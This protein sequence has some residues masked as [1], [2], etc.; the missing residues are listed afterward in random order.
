MK[1]TKEHILHQDFVLS[2]A[3]YKKLNKHD[4]EDADVLRKLVSCDYV[5][6]SHKFASRFFIKT[7]NALKYLSRQDQEKF[8]NNTNLKYMSIPVQM[9]AI[10]KN[11][12]LIKLASKRVQAECIILTPV[13]ASLYTYDEQVDIALNSG[14]AYSVVR[15]LQQEAQLKLC[16]K[17]PKMIAYANEIVQDKVITENPDWFKYASHDYQIVLA[18]ITTY[19]ISKIT[20][21]CIK[22][23]IRVSETYTKEKFEF[24]INSFY[25]IKKQRKLI[26]SIVKYTPVEFVS[27]NSLEIYIKCHPNKKF[28][29]IR[30]SKLWR[31]LKKKLLAK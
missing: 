23:Y 2:Y 4:K 3:K 24:L 20:K 14:I 7:P 22:R 28:R 18:D 16:K 15:H 13:R 21:D 12:S 25:K 29:K 27:E 19:N 1:L 30:R 11:E 9:S 17:N 5:N 6:W 10:D 26:E 8:L 31:N